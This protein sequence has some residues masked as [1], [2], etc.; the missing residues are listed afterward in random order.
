[1]LARL[2]AADFDPRRELLLEQTPSGFKTAPGTGSPGEVRTTSYHL[3]S[4]TL[5]ADLVRPAWLVMADSNYPGWRATVDSKPQQIYN[6]D[7]I[8]RAVPLAVGHHNIVFSFLP[9]MF[10]PAALVSAC[11]LV[12]V[13]V[14]LVWGRSK[15][16]ERT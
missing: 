12:V 11:S 15:R 13:L 6:A 7:F 4:V 8:L 16:Q 9:S 1:M 3:N 2:K 14:G 10:V 5:E